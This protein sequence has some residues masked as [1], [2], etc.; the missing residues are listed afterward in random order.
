M[1]C[2]RAAFLLIALQLSGSGVRG[3]SPEWSGY[4][5]NFNSV[6]RLPDP[7]GGGSGEL[8]AS[9]TGR[10]RLNF[11]WKAGPWITTGVSYDLAPRVESRTALPLFLPSLESARRGYRI[12]DFNPRLDS[13]DVTGQV[14][15]F[16]NLDRAYLEMRLPG[17]DLTV[18]RQAIAWGSGRFVS[19]SDLLTPFAYG[20]LDVEDRVGVDALRIRVP[21]GQLAEFDSG[22][23]FGRDGRWQESA[24]FTRIR[25]N[26]KRTDVSTLLMAFQDHLLVGFDL[27]RPLRG[28]GWW[29][30]AGQVLAGAAGGRRNPDEDYLRVVSGLDYTLRNGTYLFAEYHFSEAGAGDPDSY[31]TRF[32]RTSFRDGAVYFLGRHYLGAGLSRQVTPL[33]TLGGQVLTNLNDGSL[34][35]VPN[36]DY[37]LAENLYVGGG[38]YIG[39]GRGPAAGQLFRSEFGSYPDFGFVSLRI[40]Y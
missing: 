5:K 22:Y 10:F 27:A 32:Q 26:W 11:S 19:P 3:D 14:A 23:V 20:E 15:V 2:R 18:G 28:A 13:G 39:L 24:A 7:A 16:H 29:L 35:V 1:N 4:F 36:L 33:L 30:E 37:N 21:L 6:Y 9:A 25:L 17:A 40:Y 12:A 34:F 8:V 38:A 31:V